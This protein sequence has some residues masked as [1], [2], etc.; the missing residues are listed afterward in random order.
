VATLHH[1][2]TTSVGRDFTVALIRADSVITP[3][4]RDHELALLA[5]SI[6][7]LLCVGGATDGKPS[8]PFFR[9]RSDRCANQQ[10]TFTDLKDP[11]VLKFVNA[12][13][14]EKRQLFFGEFAMSHDFLLTRRFPLDEHPAVLAA[15][16]IHR[17]DMLAR[18]DFYTSLLSKAGVDNVAALKEINHHTI[19]L[20]PTFNLGGSDGS[21]RMNLKTHSL[22]SFMLLET[23]MAV[24]HGARLATCERCDAVFLTGPLTGRRSHTRFCSDR[25]RVAAMRA[26]KALKGSDHVGEE[27]GLE[28]H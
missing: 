9:F 18:Q 10:A 5:R 3:F 2:S 26:R 20:S 1:L 6:L 7:T 14:D 16:M 24:V 8:F 12:T 25:C 27:K 19:D 22:F 13:S 21:P 11:I 23:A 15:R 4:S 28:D 17:D